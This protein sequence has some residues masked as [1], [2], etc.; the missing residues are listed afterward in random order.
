[1]ALGVV[2]AACR[3]SVAPPGTAV[4][5]TAVQSIAS[6]PGG[7]ETPSHQLVAP[8]A[9]RPRVATP[10]A[11]PDP[12]G[13][14]RPAGYRLRSGYPTRDGRRN[15]QD[16]ALY[17]QAVL[18]DSATSKT[19]KMCLATRAA[20]GVLRSA[21]ER[22]GALLFPYS[23][24][25]GFGAAGRVRAPWFSGLAQ[26]TLMGSFLSIARLTGDAAYERAARSTFESLLLPRASGGLVD[27]AG[28]GAWIQEYP[29]PTPSYVLNGHLF[30]IMSA[31]SFAEVTGDARGRDLFARG[32]TAAAALLPLFDVPTP[33]G[34]IS[35]YDLLRRSDGTEI[36]IAGAVVEEAVVVDGAGRVVARPDHAAIATGVRP[37]YPVSV[38][39]VPRVFLRVAYRGAGTLEAR[40]EGGWI[41]IAT[42]DAAA[43]PATIEIP[44]RFQGRTINM[45]YHAIHVD[46]LRRLARASGN[47]EFS[48]WAD[49]WAR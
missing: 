14:R 26:T 41:R 9:T 21:I 25:Y 6:L 22:D 1:M 38:R 27:E 36:R 37:R 32:A 4:T 12:C 23:F 47:A 35:A 20:N 46:V 17:L 44:Q 16:A 49:R 30:S 33:G 24:S 10:S 42:L 40:Q 34:S 31:R 29:S 15:P 13:T 28:G 2:A 18:S 48:R 3:A 45:R 39:A 11:R 8:V 7:L 43:S 19:Q 5:R